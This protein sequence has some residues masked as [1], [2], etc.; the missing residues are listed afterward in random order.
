LAAACANQFFVEA[1]LVPHMVN[2]KL[3]GS[4]ARPVSGEIRTPADNLQI[5]D[6]EMR[7]RA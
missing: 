4:A 3:R 5:A 6:D 1:T 2:V 7:I